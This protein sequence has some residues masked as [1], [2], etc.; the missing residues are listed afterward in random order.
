MNLLTDNLTLVDTKMIIIS[1]YFV[2][3]ER[4]FGRFIL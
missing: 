3:L 2:S 1:K 4:S